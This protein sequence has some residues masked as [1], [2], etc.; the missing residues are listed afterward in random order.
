[1]NNLIRLIWKSKGKKGHKMTE[2]DDLIIRILVKCDI[3]DL[4]KIREY[5]RKRLEEK[6][7]QLKMIN[8]VIEE[9]RKETGENV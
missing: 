8:E 3:D 1:L 6:R 5:F 4:T 7:E 9:K 2:F